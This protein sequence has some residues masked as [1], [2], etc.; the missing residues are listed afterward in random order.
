MTVITVT[1]IAQAISAG[2]DY[3]VTVTITANGGTLN[4]TGYTVTCSLY[5][6]RDQATALISAHAVT[7]T[8]AASGIV[9][10]TLTAAE[11]ATLH[12]DPL[13]A[14]K[15][16]YHIANFK[17]VAGGGAV[18]PSDPFRLLVNRGLTA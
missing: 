4:L 12:S 14:S 1:D 17:C 16:V 8:T 3:A 7:L 10:L 11:T 5:D 15:G 18:T 9:T 13:E 2:G 6:Q